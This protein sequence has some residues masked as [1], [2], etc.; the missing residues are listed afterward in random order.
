MV[1]LIQA[2]TRTEAWVKATNLLLSEGPSLN[3]SLSIDSPGGRGPFPHADKRID[4]YLLHQGQLPLHTV[5]ETIFPGY[6]YRRRGTEGVFETY[7]NEIYPA[8]H[9]HPKITWGTYAY[10]MVRRQ[11]EKGEFMNPLK[12][13]IEKMASEL[14]ATGPKRSCYEIGVGEGEYDIALYNTA[15]DGSRRMGGP[16]LS[17]LSFKLFNGAIHLVAIYRSH[18]YA[19]KVPGNLLGLARLQSFV[20][21]ETGRGLGSLVVHSTYAF[22]GGGKGR[23]RTLLEQVQGQ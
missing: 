17:H 20:S 10:R 6:E 7:P 1:H 9:K 22:L 18:D 13:L 11:D 4:E 2:T 23:M 21:N 8:I 14:R 5:A 19:Y 15:K 16:C 3:L 12:Q